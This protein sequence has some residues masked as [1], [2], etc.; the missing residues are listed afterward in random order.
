MKNSG[1]CHHRNCFKNPS[2][3]LW[4]FLNYNNYKVVRIYSIMVSL[5]LRHKLLPEHQ[6]KERLQ[7]LVFEARRQVKE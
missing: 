3:L 5:H 1:K 7:N 4:Y 2:N 6:R